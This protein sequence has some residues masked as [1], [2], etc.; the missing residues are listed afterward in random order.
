MNFFHQVINLIFTF[1]LQQTAVHVHLLCLHYQLSVLHIILKVLVTT[2]SLNLTQ[3]FDQ[4]GET[5]AEMI[6]LSFKLRCQ[7]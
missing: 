2:I 5:L 1:S 3:E 7:N 4:G 6:Y